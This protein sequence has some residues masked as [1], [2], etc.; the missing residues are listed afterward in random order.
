VKE[1]SV[2]LGFASKKS[3]V[4]PFISDEASNLTPL[5][6]QN[7]ISELVNEAIPAFLECDNHQNVCQS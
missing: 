5:L 2:R 6:I 1:A 4:L 7:N 3:S